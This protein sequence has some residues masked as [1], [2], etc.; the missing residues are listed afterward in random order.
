MS[1]Q[2]VKIARRLHS[3]EEKYAAVK[4]ELPLQV[5]IVSGVRSFC[6]LW[7]EWIWRFT[8]HWERY[9]VKCACHSLWWNGYK[10]IPCRKNRYS[11]FAGQ[12]ETQTVHHLTIC[13]SFTIYW[14][15][16]TRQFWNCIFICK[17]RIVVG[18]RYTKLFT[19]FLA[20]R[21]LRADGCCAC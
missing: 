19:I 16:T 8:N 21:N 12:Q 1:A 13:N 18:V 6:E 4:I 17:L 10:T 2:T 7:D 11:Q 3:H 9:T 14:K 15:I 5:Y 20:S